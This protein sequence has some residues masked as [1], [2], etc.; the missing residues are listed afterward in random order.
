MTSNSTKQL[1]SNCTSRTKTFVIGL[2]AGIFSAVIWGLWPV[3]TRFGVTSDFTAEEIVA[4]RFTFAGMVLLPYYFQKQVWKR[5]SPFKSMVIAS[6]A[7]AIYVYVSALGLKYVP[8]G[9]LG[10]V[11]TGTMLILSALGGYVFLNEKKTSLQ[12]LSYMLIFI[13]LA[14]VN[15]QSF[16]IEATKESLYGDLLLVFGG[17]LWASYTVLSK[18]WSLASWDAVAAVSVWSFFIWV[19]LIILFGDFHI[20]IDNAGPWLVQGIGQGIVTAVLGLWLYTLAVQCLGASRGSLFGALVPAFAMLGGLL[21][22]LE[23]PTTLEIAGV[24]L[25][26]LGIVVSI[27][28]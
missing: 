28:R 12:M 14:L 15:W 13:G 24:C 18:K 11:E 5:I 17:V 9:H 26:T 7:G 25:T 10:V 23:I 19:P 1:E 27:R 22:L 2:F 3:L 20:S 21:F 6:G 16:A 4:V 8:A